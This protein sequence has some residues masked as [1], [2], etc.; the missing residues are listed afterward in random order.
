MAIA[1]NLKFISFDCYGTLIDWE[2]G[3]YQACSKEAERSDCTLDREELLNLL[4]KN[5]AEIEAGSYEL[6]AEVLRRTIVKTAKQLGW[7]LEPSRAGFLPASVEKWLPFKESNKVLERIA[8]K[9]ETGLLSNIDDKLLGVTRRHIPVD[10]DLVVT[11]QQVRSYKPEPYHFKECARRIGGKA[12]W[13][14]IAS[15]YSADVQPCLRQRISVIW[16]N[17]KKQKLDPKQKEPDAEVTSLQ[18]AVRLLG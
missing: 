17:R 16:V 12:S 4:F 2:E 6:Y 3:I 8:K 18:E 7:P 10:F 5:Q 9:Y 14:H 15:G 11:A 13:V 1:K